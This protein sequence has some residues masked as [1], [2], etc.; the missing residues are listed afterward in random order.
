[1][2]AVQTQTVQNPVAEV[3]LR[4]QWSQKPF[5]SFQTQRAVGR[6]LVAVVRTLAVA[7]HTLVAVCQILGPVDQIL[8]PAQMQKAAQ[9][10]VSAQTLNSGS[11]HQS[12]QKLVQRYHQTLS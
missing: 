9:M 10:Q 11:L 4:Q 12:A 5:G 8:E 3:A 7:A 2:M 1:M 6:M